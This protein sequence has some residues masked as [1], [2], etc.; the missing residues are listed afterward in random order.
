MEVFDYVAFCD[1]PFLGCFRMEEPLF[2]M[3]FMGTMCAV[4]KFCWVRPSL[5]LKTLV[6]KNIQYHFFKDKPVQAFLFLFS[7]NGICH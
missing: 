1:A 6:V 3:L 5:Y 7:R 4:W 2:C